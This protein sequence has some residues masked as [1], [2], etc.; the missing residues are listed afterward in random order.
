MDITTLTPV[1]AMVATILIMIFI[2]HPLFRLVERAARKRREG[3]YERAVSDGCIVTAHLMDG[4][5]RNF[6]R[7]RDTHRNKLRG[8]GKYVYTAPN[9]KEYKKKIAFTGKP[10]EEYTL[11]LKPHNYRSY[12]SNTFVERGKGI[13]YFSFLRV[14]LFCVTLVFIN[15]NM[16]HII[17]F[18]Q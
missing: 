9:G 10:P 6:N 15:D 16:L 12:Y 7:Y 3:I 18:F 14:P 8:M 13:K 1:I 2:Y 5:E 4:T 17:G 11:F